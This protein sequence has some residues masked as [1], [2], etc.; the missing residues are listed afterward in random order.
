VTAQET[1]IAITAIVAGCTMIALVVGVI[2]WQI[3]S[4]SRARMSVAREEAYKELARTSADV[5]VDTL[6]SLQRTQSELSALRAQVAEIERV[7][8]EVG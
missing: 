4:S 1:A 3:F 7:L 2:V 8:R 5:H 6:H